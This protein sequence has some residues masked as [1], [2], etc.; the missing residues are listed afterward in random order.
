MRIR[1]IKLDEANKLAEN[2][3]Y[4]NVFTYSLFGRRERGKKE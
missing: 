4:E 2:Y 3:R 1:G